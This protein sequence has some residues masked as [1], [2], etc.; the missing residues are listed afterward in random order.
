MYISKE[1]LSR[2][3]AFVGYGDFS[4]SKILFFGNEEGTSGGPDLEI[5]INRRCN[6]YLNEGIPILPGNPEAGFYIIPQ[7]DRLVKSPMLSFQARLL[8][9][10]SYPEVDWF[11]TKSHKPARYECINAY[12]ANL[13]YKESTPL[14]K[15]AL[16]DLRP[17]PRSYE[18]AWPY[19]NLIQE[20]YNK[21]FSYGSQKN[22]GNF[23]QELSMRRSEVI[24]RLLN[25]SGQAKILIG[26]GAK[27]IKKRLLSQIFNGAQFDKIELGNR[28][29]FHV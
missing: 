4:G 7:I 12:Q 3:I 5:E 16:V 17:L 14:I 18:S 27:E 21:A 26:I 6:Q 22:L 2:M 11:Q 25:N 29:C 15:S 9:H 19:E 20:K 10:L 8:L 1:Q 13:L 23:Y 28:Y 24:R